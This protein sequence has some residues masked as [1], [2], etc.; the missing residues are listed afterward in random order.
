MQHLAY[1][2]PLGEPDLAKGS[3][4]AAPFAG[5]QQKAPIHSL[6]VTRNPPI[7]LPEIS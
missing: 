1:L 5:S 4:Q 7:T 3:T 2:G 6:P